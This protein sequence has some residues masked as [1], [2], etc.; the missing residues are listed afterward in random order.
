MGAVEQ[1]PFHDSEVGVVV[2][3]QLMPSAEMAT[4]V[5]PLQIA[6]KFLPFQ[7]TLTQ[8]APIGSVRAVQVMP[9]GDMAAVVLVSPPATAQKRRGPA[10]QQMLHQVE[11]EGRVRAVHVTPSGEVAAA[12]P[13]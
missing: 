10:P 7:H 12:V 11:L 1:M 4:A 2:A 9:S 3:V 6:T 5:P 8:S 13:R